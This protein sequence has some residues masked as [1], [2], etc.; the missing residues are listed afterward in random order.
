MRHNKYTV[1]IFFFDGATFSR[2]LID[3]HELIQYITHG[4]AID[5]VRSVQIVHHPHA[6]S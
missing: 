4:F 5:Q 3:H 6:E 2:D 1:T